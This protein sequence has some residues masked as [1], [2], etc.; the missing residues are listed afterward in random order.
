M[1]RTK[2]RLI[3]GGRFSWG[4]IVFAVGVAI[5]YF[6]Q[7]VLIPLAL[8]LL[9]AFLLAPMVTRAQRVGLGRVPSV[10]LVAAFAFGFMILI[11]WIVAGQLIKFAEDLPHY[12]AEIV[13]KVSRVRG[14]G[15]AIGRNLDRLGN[16]ISHSTG[17][18]T[19][20]TTENSATEPSRTTVAE[21]VARDLKSGGNPPAGPAIGTTSDSPLYVMTVSAP[22]SSIKTL[23]SYVGFVLGPLGTGAVVIVFVI[24]LLLGRE[25]LRDRVIGLV[26]HGK[27]TVTTRAL[28]DAA[29]RISRYVLAQSIINGTYGLVVGTGLWLI[30]LGLGN[31]TGF[32]SF[33]LWG[34]LCCLL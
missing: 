21:N 27:Y 17:V 30:G 25:D 6:A 29:K 2:K 14:A 3:A 28:D 18:A 31:G 15:G 34:L 26:S 10:L 8:S 24:F 9:L 23:G 22:L 13:R 4:V 11:G 19:R 7:D 32:P 1:A 12:Q 33:V 20:A 16:E 5:L